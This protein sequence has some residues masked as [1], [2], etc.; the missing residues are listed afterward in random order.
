VREASVRQSRLVGRV[1]ELAALGQVVGGVRRAGR[2]AVV[3]GE[4]GIGKTRVIEAAVDVARV[5]GMAVLW[6]RAEEL[7]A[8]LP[9]G[10]IVDLVGRGRLDGH[11]DDGQLRPDVSGEREFR[12]AESVLELLD[13]RCA[14]GPVMLVVEDLQWADPSTLA[15]M[16][17]VA[18]GIDRLPVAL[19]VSGRPEPRRAELER[20]LAVLAARDATWV[21]LGPLDESSS[22]ELLEGLLG[23]SPGPR[24]VG[25]VRR[26][27]GNPLF[28]CELVGAL[29]A[30]GGI[31]RHDDG[32]EMAA[33]AGQPSLPLTIMHRLSFLPSDVLDLLGLAS[34]LGA[35]FAPADLGLLAGRPVAELVPAL[36][37]AQRAGVLGERGERLAFRHELVRDALYDDM[38]LGVR[39][40]L[41]GELARALADAGEPIERRVEHVL[42]AAAPGDERAVGSLVGAARDLVGR[43]PRAAV[44]VYRRAIELSTTPDARRA[45]LLPELAEALVLAGLLAEGEA[46]C[47]EA[48]GRE[49]DAGWATKLRLRLMFLLMNREGT[50]EAVGVGEAGLADPQMVGRDRARLEARVAMARLFTGEVEPAVRDAHAVLDVSNDDLARAVATSTLA[51]AAARRGAFAAATELLTPYVRWAEHAGAGRDTQPH[52]IIGPYLVFLDRL[53]EAYDTIQRGRSGAE[54]LGITLPVYHFHAGFIDFLRGRLDDALA[55]LAT[56][57]QLAELADV[58][59]HVPAHCVR[60]LIALHRDDFLAAQGH[61][62]AAQHEASRAPPHGMELL[63]LA[64]TRLLEAGGDPTT[65]LDVVADAVDTMATIG[66]TALI[67]LLGPDLARLAAVTGRSSRADRMV[68]ETQTIAE[69]NPGVRS[70]QAAVLHARGLLESDAD[71]LLAAVELLRGTGRVLET[72]RAAEDAA[73]V[74]ADA[75]DLLDEAREI[76]GRCA[77]TRDLARVEAALRRLGIRR[78]VSGPR[79]RPATGWEALTETELTVVRLVAERLTNPE[80]AERMFISRRTVQTHVSNALAKLGVT[81]RRELA[82]EAVRRAGWRLRVEG[83]GEHT[84]QPKPAIETM[85]IS[86]VD[87]DDT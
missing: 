77:A 64:R 80:I 60:A 5:A 68:A 4:A 63:V 22:V 19:V 58:A 30:D 21:R 82:A 2:I 81:T 73:T 38:P 65:A 17:R 71:A 54:T 14:G 45:E 66:A 46:A 74:S 32:A 83:V 42:R 36:R 40:S 43:A 25:Q 28:M 9:F 78:G 62:T 86:A 23:V 41:H 50:A 11:V 39:R 37:S 20:L 61:L 51:I 72:A 52:L 27:G 35:T 76:Y 67:P 59:W 15:V 16:A 8:H 70:L 34:V 47:R 12:V 69:L 6:S 29:L 84:E 49:L 79:R 55:E 75:V 85:L 18:S 87:D 48:L 3:E 56:H 31:E 53:D 26:A 44:D 10:A 57:D 1:A 24:L 13:V 7:E 33:D